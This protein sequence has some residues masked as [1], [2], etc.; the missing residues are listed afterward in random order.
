MHGPNQRGEIPRNQV[1]EVTSNKDWQEVVT[2]QDGMHNVVRTVSFVIDSLTG[3]AHKKENVTWGL[4]PTPGWRQGKSGD[5]NP[6]HWDLQQTSILVFI[7]NQGLKIDLCKLKILLTIEEGCALGITPSVLPA[8]TF[9]SKMRK[10]SLCPAPC[11]STGSDPRQDC[12]LAHNWPV[13]RSPL[14]LHLT[15]SFGV[16]FPSYLL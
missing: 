5:Q 11:L 4:F 14:F 1:P 6:K 15:L 16:Q 7:T 2:K 13:P 3:P 9:S 8:R 12:H 10:M